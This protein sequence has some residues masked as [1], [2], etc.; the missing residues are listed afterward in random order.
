VPGGQL[1]GN[2]RLMPAETF[3]CAAHFFAADTRLE[4]VYVM[5]MFRCA[6]LNPKHAEAWGAL[7]FVGLG[8]GS[9]CRRTYVMHMFRCATRRRACG[10]LGFWG[11]GC[12][13]KC[14]CTCGLSPHYVTAEDCLFERSYAFMGGAPWGRGFVTLN[15]KPRCPA[16]AR[17][18]RR[19][20]GASGASA[21]PPAPTRRAA[22]AASASSSTAPPRPPPPRARTWA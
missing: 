5:H 3:G 2:T 7:G 13:P 17:A 9:K 11:L 15:P 4:S 1:V 16:A 8:C 12:G 14:R 6:C 20:A 22:S 19:C 21:P 18:A 10:A